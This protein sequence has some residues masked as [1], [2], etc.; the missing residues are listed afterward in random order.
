MRGGNRADADH[1]CW[2]QKDGDVLITQP[3]P[4]LCQYGTTC[5]NMDGLTKVDFT[6][7]MA[8]GAGVVNSSG[9]DWV[10]DRSLVNACVTIIIRIW[11]PLLN[12]F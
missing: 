10:I 1:A 6:D 11:P 12:I 3:R 9:Y 2:D 5:L 4:A 7:K 8:L